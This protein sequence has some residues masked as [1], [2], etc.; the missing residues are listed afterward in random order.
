MAFSRFLPGFGTIKY[1]D[2]H[3]LSAGNNSIQNT[4]NHTSGQGVV[5]L[6]KHTLKSECKTR[7]QP[8]SGPV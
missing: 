1:Y 2:L 6:L 5:R 4:L 8:K 7:R 3:I